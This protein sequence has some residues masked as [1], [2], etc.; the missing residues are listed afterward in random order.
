MF[1]N[2][3][4]RHKANLKNYPY[5]LN[6]DKDQRR[7]TY[8]GGVL[9]TLCTNFPPQIFHILSN[10]PHQGQS[11]TIVSNKELLCENP[12]QARAVSIMVF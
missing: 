2:V 4:K 11:E 10:N 1:T 9:A 8:W 12:L 5:R 6:D 3:K 7:V